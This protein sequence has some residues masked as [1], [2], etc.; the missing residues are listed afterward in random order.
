MERPVE[1][2][3]PAMMGYI[4]ARGVALQPGTPS[5]VRSSGR[6]SHKALRHCERSKSAWQSSQ[7]NP[8]ASTRSGRGDPTW[9][10]SS[11]ACEAC[12][13]IQF[14]EK[15][16]FS[17]L[18]S[19]DYFPST[20]E[21]SVRFQYPGLPRALRALAMTEGRTGSPRHLTR[22]RDDECVAGKRRDP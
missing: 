17:A 12:V 18:K 2:G 7:Q 11:R 14:K 9:Y 21:T 22:A 1:H 6:R 8:F 3:M 4:V 15:S 16:I 5:R 19:S 20:I 10:S 13:A